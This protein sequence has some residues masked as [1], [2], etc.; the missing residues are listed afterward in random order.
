MLETVPRTR[1][2]FV[3]LAYALAAIMVGTTV[4]TPMYMLFELPGVRHF[5]RECHA[6]HASP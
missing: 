5:N 6:R 1:Y 2:A 3:L 4:P